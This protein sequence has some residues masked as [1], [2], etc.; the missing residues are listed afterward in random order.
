M[1]LSGSTN[2]YMSYLSADALHLTAT[3]SALYL[4]NRHAQGEACRVGHDG[5]LG[6]V[7]RDGDRCGQA[8]RGLPGTTYSGH[9][10]QF[11]VAGYMTFIFDSARVTVLA[12]AA[13][14]VG[15]PHPP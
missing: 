5:W 9:R 11:F 8:R 3:G 7:C 10:Y 14:P 12:D 4:F 2:L 15:P 1:D 13:L 6:S